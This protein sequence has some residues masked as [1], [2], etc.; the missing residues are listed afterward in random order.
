MD[1][2][3]VIVTGAGRGIGRA[4]AREF[5][6]HGYQL[7]L[8][9]RTRSE[10]EET[11]RL[12]GVEALI[13]EADV[14][15]D[16]QAARIVQAAQEKFGRV[17]ALV[18]N[19]GYAPALKMEELTNSEWARILAVNLTAPLELMRA[20]WPVF[21]G[22]GGAIVN[23]SSQAARDPFPTLG[24]YGAAKAAL[25]AL[26]LWAARQGATHGI[27]VYAV[28]P[29]ATETAMFRAMLTEEQYPRQKTLDPAEVARVIYQCVAGDL[30]W[31]SG[32]VH[33]LHKTI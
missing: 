29:A 3:V 2:P 31:T 6:G 25:N 30:R 4:T 28:A 27:R 11:A 32:E 26:T 19:A 22:G 17:D 13:L 14:A 9:S 16:G 24:A 23:I 21:S 33:Y 1:F 10:L 20:V 7:V 8:V 5:A 15:G 18:N 12:C